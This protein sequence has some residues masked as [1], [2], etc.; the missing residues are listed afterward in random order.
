MFK[1][2]GSLVPGYRARGGCGRLNA[3]V[4]EIEEAEPMKAVMPVA[5]PDV[6]AFRKRPGADR[7]DEM[8][9]GVLHMVPA[10]TPAHQDL[11]GELQTY[12]KV[13]WARPRKAKV[14]HEVNLAPVGG[15]PNSYRIPDL[16]LL[17][18]ERFGIT[19][20]QHFEG[21]PDAV[22]E[23]HSP[24]DEAY[25]KLPFY[26]KLGVPEVWYIQRV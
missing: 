7:F 25:E 10:P 17:T 21:A 18:P 8:W 24:G 22:V 13:H 12:L 20:E 19:R 4:G 3:L 1:S 26:A 16:L 5:L 14:Y 6:L 9:E 11:A 15:W 23:F 2:V